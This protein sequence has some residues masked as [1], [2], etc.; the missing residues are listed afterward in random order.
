MVFDLQLLNI[1]FA[2]GKIVIIPSLLIVVA[3]YALSK[4]FKLN[5]EQINVARKYVILPLIGITLIVFL[6]SI[7][8]GAYSPK[9]KHESY[10][11]NGFEKSVPNKIERIEIFDGASKEELRNMTTQQEVE[12]DSRIDKFKNSE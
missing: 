8:S 7:N 12:Q 6:M 3:H 5:K 2:F 10:V 1:L 9:L 4:M 11:P